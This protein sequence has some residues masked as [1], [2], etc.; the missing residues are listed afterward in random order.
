MFWMPWRTHCLTEPDERACA[1]STLL[2]ARAS[3]AAIATSSSDIGVS[4]AFMPVSSSPERLSL[5]RVDAVFDQRAHGAAH[6]LRAADDDAEVEALVRNMRG[7]RVA[8]AADG[9]DLRPRRACSAGPGMRPGV[10]EIADDDVEPGL[11]RRRAAA[12]W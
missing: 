3:E 6:L 2:R 7:R 8:E 10:D 11:G 5:M 4:S 1:A 12:R 9:G